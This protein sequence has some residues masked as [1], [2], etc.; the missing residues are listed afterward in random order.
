MAEVFEQALDLALD[1]KDPKRKLERR[2][3]KAER[4][5]SESRPDE[6][7][8]EKE[9]QRKGDRSPGRSRYIPSSRRERAFARASYQCEYHG[10]GGVRCTERTGLEID[11][12][13]PY[14]KGGTNSESNLRV[15]CPSHNQ[16]VAA[17]EFG[18]AFVRGKV[19]ERRA[20]QRTA[21]SSTGERKVFQLAFEQT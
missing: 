20:G 16:F 7:E 19:E 6:V 10:P 21:R 18:E 11:H 5:R 2:Q 13:V 15:L 1:K 14:A 9:P 17:Q 12:V 8:P 4:S 3:K